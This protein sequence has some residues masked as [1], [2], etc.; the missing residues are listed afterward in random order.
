VDEDHKKQD[1]FMDG[2]SDALQYQLMNHRFP[3]F[4]NLV[5]RALLTERKH[6]DMMEDRK[7]KF[8]NQ[9]VGSSSRPR[10]IGQ[11]AQQFCPAGSMGHASQPQQNPRMVVQQQQR[12]QQPQQ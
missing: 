8:P 11:P 2:L 10:Y 9:Q 12:L 4:Q 7:H 5:D 3:T 6:R 1:L